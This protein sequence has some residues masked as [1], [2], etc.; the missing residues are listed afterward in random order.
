[1]TKN[2]PAMLLAP[3]PNRPNRPLGTDAVRPVK[4]SVPPVGLIAVPVNV[5]YSLFA[6]V[7]L[8]FLASVALPWRTRLPPKDRKGG[9]VMVTDTARVP[10]AAFADVAVVSPPLNLTSGE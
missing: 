9:N 4:V 1:M 5:I 3:G 6:V 8:A 10:K 7:P 2:V